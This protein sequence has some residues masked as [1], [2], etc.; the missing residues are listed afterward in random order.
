MR[1]R[2]DQIAKRSEEL[3]DHAESFDPDMAQ[4]LP[5][6]EYRLW[7]VARNRAADEGQILDAMAEAHGNGV[8][9]RRIAEIVGISA[10]AATDLC[11]KAA[12]RQ[13]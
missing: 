9:T 4:Q 7:R 6:A 3:A 1:L 12:N 2:L 10:N 13:P 11:E 8:S 5:I